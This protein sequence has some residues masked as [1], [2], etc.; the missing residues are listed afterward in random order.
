MYYGLILVSVVM[1]GINFAL[2]DVYRRL[3][4]SGLQIS[5]ESSFVGSLAGLVILLSGVTIPS[6]IQ[7]PIDDL[8]KVAT[9]LALFLL[10]ASIDFTKT[11]AHMKQLSI[12]VLGKLAVCPL[13]AVTAAALLGMRNVELASV[14]IIFGAPTAVNSAVM[15]QQMGSDGD[16]ATEAVVFTT[17][18]SALTVFL[19]VFVMKTVGVI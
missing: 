8:A 3:R 4:G 16:L 5:M 14:L 9:P 15:A 10:G 12:F 1:F 18:F 13:I 11:G 7:K 6:I 19:F 2:N 17:A